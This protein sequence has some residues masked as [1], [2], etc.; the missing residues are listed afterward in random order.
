MWFG[1][2]FGT[3]TPGQSEFRINFITHMSDCIVTHLTDISCIGFQLGDGICFL[4]GGWI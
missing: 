4:L 3:K 2:S 1:F